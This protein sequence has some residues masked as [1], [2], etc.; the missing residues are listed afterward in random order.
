MTQSTSVLGVI[1]LGNVGEPLLQ[2]LAAT[3]HEVVGV[4]SD[5]AALD[6]V[7]RRLRSLGLKDPLVTL[8]G[9]PAV[10]A[11]AGLVIE[12]VDEDLAV[13]SSVLRSLHELCPQDTVL[14][15]TTALLPLSHLAAASG[16][17]QAT[18]GLRLA[19]PTA[20]GGTVEPVR[21]ALSSDWSAGVLDAVLEGCGLRRAALG[22][23]PAADAS[24]LVLG[25]ANRAAALAASGEVGRDSIDTAMRLG[26]GLP[27]GPLELLDRI[28]LDTAR[29][30]L[31][32]LRE[33][34]GDDSFAPAP[35]LAEMIA[36]GRTGR[37]A[38]AGFHDY[39][40]CGDRAV[41]E[42]PVAGGTGAA[43]VASVGVLG[44]G[45][46]A[47]GIAEVMASAGIR[48]VLVAR[49][50]L[51]AEATVAAVGDSLT[52]AVRRGRVTP[53]DRRAALELLVPASDVAA[54]ADCDLVVE[55]VVE[56][57]AVKREVFA[58]LGRHCKPSTVLA[59]TTSSLPVTACAVASGRPGQVVG[60][61]FFNP[62]P[63]MK[64]VE[65][66]STEVS[67]DAAVSLARDVCARLGKTVVDCGD[68]AG[69][70]VNYLLFPYLA[71]AIRLLERPDTDIVATDEAVQQG[72]GFPMGPFLLLD[73]IGLDVSVAIL[74]RLHG[75]F[76]TRDF[77]PPAMLERLVSDGALGRKNGRGFHTAR[78][79]RSEQ[80]AR[81]LG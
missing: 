47:R 29:A 46:M 13:K 25:F 22:A 1:G 17:P 43:R 38:R 39:D 14:V 76:A 30:T 40:E 27:V 81:V 16:R 64:L 63:V 20:A 44:S 33:A 41:A 69:F 72:Y 80:T 36:R 67:D 53:E 55:A 18:L 62:A 28:G 24:A 71:D 74:R 73:T 9:D 31:A 12:A 23:A 10:L 5:H 3:G 65:V 37:K 57:L 48:T 49:D 26:C 75:E 70:I 61:H 52:R 66:V 8:S 15:T 54:V 34:T 35:V 59:T 77:V 2:L 42:Q 6:R 58:A 51:K 68:R 4:D 7:D 60:M 32:A 11:T 45:A 79:S 56:D 78:W 50:R 21:T 19:V